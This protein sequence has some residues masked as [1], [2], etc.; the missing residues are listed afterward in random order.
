MKSSKIVF[1]TFCYYCWC[2]ELL[3]LAPTLAALIPPHNYW[4]INKI[5]NHNWFFFLTEKAETRNGFIAYSRSSTF[6]V[7]SGQH[8]PFNS[9]WY[10]YGSSY[11][12]R[13]YQF[14]A[15]ETGLYAFFLTIRLVYYLTYKID[16]IMFP[17]ISFLIVYKMSFLYNSFWYNYGRSSS[18]DARTSQFIAQVTGLYAFF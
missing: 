10:S 13:T 1:L 8:M 17:W 3:Q 11:D 16:I 15:P 14:T 7:T 9:M 6:A 2:L 5:W 12:A 18:N 4:L